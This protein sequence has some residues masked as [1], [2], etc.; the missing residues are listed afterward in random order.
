MQLRSCFGAPKLTYLLRSAP[1]WGHPLLETID[2]Q[3][4]HGLNIEL[5]DNQ[6]LQATLPIRDGGLG[7]RRVTMLASS[8]FLASA[9]STKTL[10]AAILDR[11]E[12]MD[13]FEKE[14]QESRRSTL[15][16]GEAP[17]WN[18]QKTWDRPLIDQDKATVWSANIDPLNRARLGAVSSPHAG[19][20]LST[21]P[22]ASCGLGLSNE[23]I[24][25]AIG[26]RLGLNLC[27]SHQ[28]QCGQIA[29]PGGHHGLVC[30]Q[31][32]GR[33]SRHFAMN[34][35]IWRAL[36]KADIPSSKEPPG[37]LR[38]DG[39]R[40]DGATLVPW[41]GG[42]YIT[43]DVTS[44][45]TCATSYIQM[46]ST[47]PGSAAELA[48]SRKITKYADLPATHNFVPIALES[49]GPINRSG[50][51]FI[52]ELGRRVTAATG[53]PLETTYLFQRLSICTQRYNAIAFR[54]TFMHNTG[55]EDHE[56]Y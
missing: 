48:A 2:T 26:L 50:R 44:I 46:T 53:D 36:Q 33:A 14:I 18:R 51:E 3:M 41:A 38:T 15:P 17:A 32:G 45:H 27:A 28:C 20:W 21:V 8:A 47:T 30:K 7:V 31:S 40:P 1:C 22:I 12:L 56:P 16:V 13:D 6:W 54:G 9:A 43:W 49:L 25:V 19:D 10:R 23:A 52:S 34:D 11:E 35:A 42:K 5:N 37:L 4:R 39:K 29:D 24:R 55:D